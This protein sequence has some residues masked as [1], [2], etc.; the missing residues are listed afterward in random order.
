VIK[1]IAMPEDQ[2]WLKSSFANFKTGTNINLCDQDF[3][4]RAYLRK[5]FI[6]SN[7]KN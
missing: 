7:P 5:F 6:S 3:G 1:L 2:K 4:L